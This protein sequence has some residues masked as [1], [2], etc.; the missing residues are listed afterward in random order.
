[1]KLAKILLCGAILV[2]G[3][4][5]K[6]KNINVN[7]NNSNENKISESSYFFKKIMQ[8]RGVSIEVYKNGNLIEIL[9][10]FDN[11]GKIGDHILDKYVVFDS[12]SKTIYSK[13]YIFHK[14]YEEPH[15]S[16][17]KENPSPEELEIFNQV[18][19]EYNQMLKD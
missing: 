4:T 3:C 8:P 15:K 10:D 19:K 2:A 5:E 12:N 16:S 1:M 13:K 14:N 17:I 7:P 9:E 18:N 6:S 11:S